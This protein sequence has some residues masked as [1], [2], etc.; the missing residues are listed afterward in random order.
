MQQKKYTFL[1]MYWDYIF[2]FLSLSAFLLLSE[3]V[4][5]SVEDNLL[6]LEWCCVMSLWTSSAHI[7]LHLWA[8]PS[9]MRI[10]FYIPGKSH[11]KHTGLS[12]SCIMFF[13][14]TPYVLSRRTSDQMQ[15]LIS[16][17]GI[18]ACYICPTT[19]HQSIFL[20]VLLISC[21]VT[22]LKFCSLFRL[23]ILTYWPM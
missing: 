11:N 4:L 2:I 20:L 13:K 17:N 7:L 16:L 23:R 6:F 1:L 22:Q 8:S 5:L 18:K 14:Y 9:E 12:L 19:L 21:E 3:S 10:C 15:T